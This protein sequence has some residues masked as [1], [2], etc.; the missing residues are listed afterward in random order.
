MLPGVEGDAAMHHAALAEGGLTAVA[1]QHLLHELQA[2]RR[3]HLEDARAFRPRDAVGT[4]I[5]AVP[6]QHHLALVRGHVGNGGQQGV[7]QHPRDDV[8]VLRVLWPHTKAW[9]RRR[10]RRRLAVLLLLLLRL[11]LKHACH[12]RSSLLQLLSGSDCRIRLRRL[13]RVR[14]VQGFRGVI[15]QLQ[16]GGGRDG[17]VVRQHLGHLIEQ[18]RR[19]VLRRL[20]GASE[21]V[22]TPLR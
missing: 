11:L 15:G 19:L 2:L 16:R 3:P 8:A 21:G 5:E 17:A 4:R 18:H 1:A 12:Q 9:R 14:L 7:V 10:R 6:E 13:G 22:Q 20:V